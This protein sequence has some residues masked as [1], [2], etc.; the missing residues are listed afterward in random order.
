ME[1][2]RP[3]SSGGGAVKT[4]PAP[5]LND[6]ARGGGNSRMNAQQQ[7]QQDSQPPTPSRLKRMWRK[8]GL[9]AMTLSIM[10]KGSIPPIIAIAM[11]QSNAVAQQY[12]TLGYLV[13]IMSILGFSIMPRGK[14][15]Q[16]IA[17]DVIA[18]CV[19]A[20]VNL[21]ALYCMTQARKHTTPPHHP[22]TGY[23]S[24]AS[25]VGAIWLILQIYLA[26]VLRA[27]R[28]QFQFPVI[29]YSIF[30]IVSV[31]Y[32]VL[33]P[34]MAYA[35]SFMKR[36]LEAF[37]TGFG[38]A[39]GVHFVI[40]PTSSRKV[41]FK[42]MTG[43]LMCLTSM[44]KAQTAYMASIEDI[45]P[46]KIR[47]SQEKEAH[48][49]EKRGKVASTASPLETPASIQLTEVLNKTIE[50]H[51][52]LHGDITPAK[53]EFAFGKLESHDL[54][55][56][57]KL[58][59]MIFVPIIGLNGSI[60]LLKRRAADMDWAHK[61]ATKEEEDLR[62]EQLANVHFL[63]KQLHEPFAQM[64]TEIEAAIM[65]VLI[66][67]ELVKPS[68]K[69]N[70]EE[71]EGDSPVPGSPAFAESYKRK[72]DDF[73]HIKERKLVEWCKQHGIELPDNFFDSTPVRP[74]SLK[75]PD[76]NVRERFQKQLFLTLYLEYL[77]WR[78][79]L[80][81]LDL[82]LYV[83]KRK[84]DGAMKRSKLIFPGSKT[85]Y[86]WLKAPFVQED[87][88]HETSYIAE[89]DAGASESLYLGEDFTWRKDPEHEPPANARERIGEVLRLI[90]RFFRS[91][92][93]AFAFRVTAATMS[94]AIVGFLEASQVWFQ[95]QRILWAMIMVAISMTRMAGQS[96]F[97]FL[98]RLL[99][100]LIA[101]IG[102]YIIWYIV[103][104]KT[105]GV[106]VFLWLWIFLAFYFVIK[107]PKLI[108]IAILSLV[109]AVLI[110]GY[111]LQTQ[112]IGKKLSESNG[113]PA[114]PTYELAPYR[115]ATVAA[116]LFVAFIWTIFPFPV[117]E[118]SELRKDLGACLY[119][120]SNFY[121]V[122]HETVQARIK[123]TDGDANNKRSHAYHLEKARNTVFSKL[124]LLLNTLR[125]NATFSTFQI[126]LGGKFPRREYLTIIE[127]C[128]RLLQ[129]TALIGYA[130]ITFSTQDRADEISQWSNDFRKLIAFT[131][132]TSHQ[133]TSLLSLLSSSISNGQPLPPYLE[134]PP[135]FQLVKHLES[136]DT[137]VLCIRHIA[138]VEYSA[139]A[140]LQIC[141]QAVN[142]DVE[143]L[144]IHVRN[145]VGVV[146][147]SFHAVR[148]SETSSESSMRGIKDNAGN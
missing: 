61:G 112:K 113:Q 69:K 7:P 131:G 96:I 103:D 29:I 40:F 107:F 6:A 65:H 14:F 129:Y 119:L 48:H 126:Q 20:A 94:I 27:A 32:G 116:G 49:S 108:I 125:T 114:Y 67:L 110:I 80:S 2:Q 23:N 31:M 9:D 58:L 84:Q 106:I 46:I 56:L 53:R 57:W 68:K 51:T 90:P 63:M 47:E 109:T 22:P 75:L 141:A 52:K 77:L 120:L 128:Q 1:R 93:S 12:Q 19:G 118:S 91:D 42:E 143:L 105:G 127:I 122:V 54:T 74:E 16:T 8:I 140:V 121:S 3:G 17:L 115:L 102:A 104:G 55:E 66:I 30:T 18:S 34:D 99:G 146:D 88:S 144:T 111:E 71:S 98:G 101:M 45:D 124:M 15:I 13:A 28:P 25:A 5:D 73:Y 145:L 24:S 85:L 83:D 39:T 89:L 138:E 139:F 59:R 33:F 10:L 43:Y 133:I 97:N 50:L 26:N 70:D 142:Q 76:E 137:D 60:N 11:Y 81:V 134:M 136:I 117:S 92:A 95:D 135:P 21:L 41:V 86:K 123:G 147:F 37:L 35:L 72:V 148:S 82:V 79:G 62:Q 78:T 87:L 64:T 130:S 36:L 44:L 100:T 132:T 38:I 4:T